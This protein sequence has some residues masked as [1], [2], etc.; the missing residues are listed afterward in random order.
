LHI[1]LVRHHHEEVRWLTGQMLAND[2]SLLVIRIPEAKVSPLGAAKAKQHISFPGA[3]L[4][5]G[6][7]GDDYGSHDEP[8]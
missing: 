1:P 7:C 5:L 4:S 3:D 8:L 6:L 2:G